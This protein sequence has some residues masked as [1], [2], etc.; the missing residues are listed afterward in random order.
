MTPRRSE[1]SEEVRAIPRRSDKCTPGDWQEVREAAEEAVGL[2]SNKGGSSK[3]MNRRILFNS[4]ISISRAA[5]QSPVLF[6]MPDV[7]D[8]EASRYSR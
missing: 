1:D 4:D 6:Q 8:P 5:W 7:P 2:G 3:L